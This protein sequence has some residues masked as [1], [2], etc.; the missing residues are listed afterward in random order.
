[1]ASMSVFF[2]IVSLES[3]LRP[4]ALDLTHVES[5]P[6]G[7]AY[8]A[9]CF[10]RILWLSFGE[11][12]A[13]GTVQ[14]FIRS[15]ATRPVSVHRL[16]ARNLDSAGYSLSRRRFFHFPGI[17]PGPSASNP[18]RRC[19]VSAGLLWSHHFLCDFRISD[20][21]HLYGEIWCFERHPAG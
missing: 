15:N 14:D 1:M 9:L 6:K 10:L 7:S 2:A 21:P 5:W 12:R 11:P 19:S 8:S 13:H 18:T 17:R 20:H 4:R 3:W 16:A